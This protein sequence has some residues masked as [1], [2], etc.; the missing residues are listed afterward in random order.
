MGARDQIAANTIYGRFYARR[1]IKNGLQMKTHQV[2]G[3]A[4]TP[5][6][7]FIF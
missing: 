3:E 1:P 2:A 6:Y 4:S 7:Q 5:V